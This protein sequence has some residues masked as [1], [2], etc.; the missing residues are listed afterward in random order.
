LVLL[1]ILITA[2][3]WLLAKVE[4][5]SGSEVWFWTGSELLSLVPG[6]F[7]LFLRRA[8]YRMTLESFCDDCAIGF[9]TLVA[10]RQVRVGAGVYIGDRCSIGMATIEDHATIGSNVDILSGN[11]QHFIDDLDRPIQEQ[12][13]TYEPVRIGRNTWIGNSAVIMADV[14]PDCVVGAGSVVVRPIPER[15]IAVGNPARVIRTR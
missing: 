11:R 15:S 4:E 1:A 5:R 7:G 9:G 3:L 14:A 12:G 10:H 13:G 2:P 6:P 8:Y